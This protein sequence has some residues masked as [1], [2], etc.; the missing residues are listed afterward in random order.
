[1]IFTYFFTD[2]VVWRLSREQLA[3]AEWRLGQVETG[4][5]AVRLEAVQTEATE[6]GYAAVDDLIFAAV[7]TCE[8]L[9]DSAGPGS[10]STACPGTP[11]TD[12]SG[13]FTPDQ[14]SYINIVEIGIMFF[15][16]ADKH[17]P[18]GSRGN[19]FCRSCFLLI[20]FLNHTC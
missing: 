15:L 6:P 13:C 11:C 3:E 4:G 10:S 16:S 20:Y 19:G 12:S 18:C 14:G 17:H 1:M 8:T 9:P 7:D 5:Q 2:Q